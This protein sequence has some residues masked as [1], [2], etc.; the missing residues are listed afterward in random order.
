[1]ADFTEGWTGPID[2]RLLAQ[3]TTTSTS[4]P[5]DVT[6]MTVALILKDAKGRIVSTSDDVSLFNSTGGVVRYIPDTRDFL[7]RR[8]PF[9]AKF[10]VTDSTGRVVFFPSGAPDVWRV[11]PQ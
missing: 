2:V 8:S 9:T 10:A 6:N 3:A 11:Y 1:M 4:A 7:T 5:Y